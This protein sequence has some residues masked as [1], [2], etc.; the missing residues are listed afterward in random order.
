MK[1]LI[2]D[3]DGV[4][5]PEYLLPIYK[6]SNAIKNQALLNIDKNEYNKISRETIKRGEQGLYNFV[7]NLCQKNMDKYNDFCINM[8][9]SID[10]E[11]NKIK[12]DD[13]LFN[14]LLKTGKKYDICILTNNCKTH[15]EKVYSKL[16]EKNIEEFPFKSYDISFTLDNGCFHPKQSSDGFTNFIKKIN[17]NISDCIVVDDSNKNIERCIENKIPYEHITPK[18]TL[19]MF[20]NKLNE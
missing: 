8:I 7:L 2:I 6:I 3:C 10:K 20:L 12:K 13:E 11:Y 14:L 19:K 17:K 9:N 5:Y 16:F 15:L 18:N 4:L 1:T